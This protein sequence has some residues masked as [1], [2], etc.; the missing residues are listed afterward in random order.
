M[1]SSVIIVILPI[2]TITAPSEWRLYSL[3]YLSLGSRLSTDDDQRERALE[4]KELIQY[5]LELNSNSKIPA[6]TPK[7]LLKYFMDYKFKTD[8]F[9]IA[10]DNIKNTMT[11]VDQFTTSEMKHLHQKAVL[12][13]KLYNICKDL[14]IPRLQRVSSTLLLILLGLWKLL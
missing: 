11:Q 4:G 5:V 8:M 10:K 7:K 9:R 2:L 13:K 6:D 14:D 3:S 1:N 12:A